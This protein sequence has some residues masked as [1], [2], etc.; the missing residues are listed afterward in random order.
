MNSGTPKL[1]LKKCKTTIDSCLPVV[2]FAL[3]ERKINPEAQS[4][5][6]HDIVLRHH[7]IKIYV[8]KKEGKFTFIGSRNSKI[9]ATRINA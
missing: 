4:T 6:K 5:K 8:I 1:R 7:T 2:I 9:L 3:V